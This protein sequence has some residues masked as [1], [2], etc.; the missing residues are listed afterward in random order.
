MGQGPSE[1]VRVGQGSYRYGRSGYGRS[2]KSSKQK[3][4]V[5]TRARSV[6]LTFSFYRTFIN[7][8]NV[9]ENSFR[10]LRLLQGVDIIHGFAKSVKLLLLT[11]KSYVTVTDF[12][13][14][15][16]TSYFLSS[17]WKSY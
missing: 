17:N 1:K 2:K 13:K 14:N 8:R 7:I 12:L 10:A 9:K 6:I 4:V 3:K 5:T 15:R 16:F 11:G